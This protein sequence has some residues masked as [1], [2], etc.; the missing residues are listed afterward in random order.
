MVVGNEERGRDLAENAD[1]MSTCMRSGRVGGS[2]SHTISN[3][4]PDTETFLL[5]SCIAQI[6]RSGA[7]LRKRMA[8]MRGGIVDGPAGRSRRP[9]RRATTTDAIAFAVIDEDPFGLAV[10]ADHHGFTRPRVRPVPR[11]H[12]LLT[13]V[14]AFNRIHIAASIGRTRRSR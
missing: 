1:L 14:V 6:A 12:N 5:G 9:G 13:T 4:W 3:D 2:I 7:L 10:D 11:R 8:V